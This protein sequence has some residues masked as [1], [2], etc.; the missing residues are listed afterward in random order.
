MWLGIVQWRALVNTLCKY[1]KF[2]KTFIYEKQGHPGLSTLRIKNLEGKTLHVYVRH[3]MF[4]RWGTNLK[5]EVVRC[6]QNNAGWGRFTK[7]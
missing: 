4:T 3:Y 5:F 6:N 2:H 1:S 7:V